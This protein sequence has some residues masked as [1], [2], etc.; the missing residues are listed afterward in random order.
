MAV[1]RLLYAADLHGDDTHYAALVRLARARRPAALLLGGD[2]F[3]HSHDPAEQ[4]AD[5]SGCTACRSVG[6]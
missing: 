1:T 6:C 2:L 5:A 4:V 3:A